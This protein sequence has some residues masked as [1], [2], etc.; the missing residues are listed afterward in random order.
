M[1]TNIYFNEFQHKPEQ[2]LIEDLFAECIQINGIDVFYIPKTL[3]KQ[4]QFYGEDVLT[5]FKEAQQIEMY[6][7][8]LEG[9]EGEGDFISKFGIEIKD[10]AT[11][12]ASKMR[13]KQVLSQMTRPLEG[14]LIYLPI[15]KTLWSIQFVEDEQPFYQRGRIHVYKFRCQ[16]FEY[17]HERLDTNIPEIDDIENDFS[18]SNLNNDLTKEPFANNDTIEEEADETLDFE[19]SN[20]FGRY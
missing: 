1:V 6:L 15:N 3:I 2:N 4:D 5:Q 19:E 8:T 18:L 14:D 13:F 7:E 11:F 10:Q 20:P 17:S 9:W 16:L 12:V